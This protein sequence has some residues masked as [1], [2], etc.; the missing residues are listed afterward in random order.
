MGTENTGRVAAMDPSGSYRYRNS[1]SSLTVINSV[2]EHLEDI[3]N[4]NIESLTDL[5][6]LSAKYSETLAY[7]IEKIG[8]PPTGDSQT[9][10]VLQNFWF[11]NSNKFTEGNEFYDSQIKY[12]QDYTYNVYAYVLVVG[13]KYKFSNLALTR[14]IGSTAISATDL[15]TGVE[16]ETEYNC[17]EFYDPTSRTQ[18]SVEQLSQLAA[19]NYLLLAADS[20]SGDRAVNTFATNAHR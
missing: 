19:D 16:T 2:V 15:D 5:Y 12:N 8:G 10:N 6:D 1:V 7:R 18:V 11:I 13:S 9:P 14:Q 17:L 20:V 3:S 4:F